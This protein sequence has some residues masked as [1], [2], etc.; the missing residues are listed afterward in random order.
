MTGEPVLFSFPSVS[1]APP[2]SHSAPGLL[3]LS[4][5][6]QPTDF[7]P[8]RFDVFLRVQHTP[9]SAKS[10]HPTDVL[11]EAWRE[12]R[13]VSPREFTLSSE[14]GEITI[15]FPELHHLIPQN[16]ARVEIPP[17]VRC[18]MT[19]E[20]I[21]REFETEID[22][23]VSYKK[24]S[25]S[26]LDSPFGGY[27][28]FEKETGIKKYDPSIYSR[29]EKDSGGRLVLVDEE[30]GDE[31]GEVGGKQVSS[32][33]VVPGS[34]D[35]V[36]I[37]FPPEGETGPITVRTA[38]YLRDAS[39]PAYQNSTIVQTAATASRLIVTTSSYIASAMTAGA[40]TF[41]EK[42]KPN[43]TP[44]TFQPSTHERFQKVHT[45]SSAAAK[46]SAATVGRVGE[47]AQNAGAKLAGKEKEHNER[48]KPRNP[49]IL[50]KSLIAFST[51]AD[52]IDHAG[53]NLL[54]S[55]S[56]AATQVVGHRYGAEAGQVAQSLTGAARNVG[57]VYIDALGVSRRAVVKGVA[58]GMVVGKVKGGG[59]VIL[60]AQQ[61]EGG[62]PAWGESVTPPPPGYNQAYV[63]GNSTG[64]SSALYFSPPPQEKGEKRESA[65]EK[66]RF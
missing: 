39:R 7:D 17:E 10:S 57:L 31:V 28:A 30:N 29:D 47:L 14:F 20:A 21:V 25:Y 34:K 42:T 12:L 23:F 5:S 15:I 66:F 19:W 4:S 59:E 18:T 35:P 41:T 2:H 62:L 64:G 55:G 54:A 49:N 37:T 3:V 22:R 36:E 44:M 60:P 45:L 8:S 33:G 43:T 63:T 65:S 52:S 26:L 53:R 1:L 38:D 9:D 56:Q 11:I 51:V 27:A 61:P 46:F 48:G 16:D 24:N 6:Q 40:R 32:V 58:K 50:N 13:K